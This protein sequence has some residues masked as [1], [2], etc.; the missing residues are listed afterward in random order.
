M[1]SDIVRVTI[2]YYSY[3]ASLNKAE[4]TKYLFFPSI[5]TTIFLI[6]R[7]KQQPKPNSTEKHNTDMMSS[8]NAA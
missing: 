7:N 4:I 6:R 8:M 1:L 2:Y 5:F 3:L